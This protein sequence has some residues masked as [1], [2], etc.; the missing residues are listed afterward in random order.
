MNAQI[1]SIG[2]ELAGGQT[3]DTNAAWLAR[4]LAMLGI[5]CSK[6]VTIADELVPIR[7]S[8]VSVS[9]EADL[10]LITGGLGPTPDDLTRTALAEAMG[11]RLRFHQ[12]S[13]ARIEAFFKA[14]KR[15]MHADNRNQAMFPESAEPIENGCGTAPGIYA[16]LNDADIFCLPGVPYEMKAMFEQSVRPR[17]S[18]DVRQQTILHQTLRTFGM[19]EAEVGDKLS[20]LMRRDRNPNVGTSAAD[21]VISVRFHARGSSESEASELIDRDAAEIRRRLGKV[22]FGESEDTL[23]DAVAR[24]LIERRQTLST[25]ESC[26]G[27]LLAKRLTDVSGASSYLIQGIVAYAN[28][29]KRD[30]LQIPMDLIETHGAVSAQVAEAMAVNCRRLS[31]T[32]YALAVTGIAGPTGATPGK[33]VGLVYIA[34]AAPV[35]TVVKELRLGENLTRTQ[36]RDRTAKIALNLLRL[37]LI[38][39]S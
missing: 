23:A 16:R 36:I 17:F 13:F 4:Q 2:S 11:V 20:D 26:T 35:E 22:V 14:R 15:R 38:G 9:R 12:V 21:L 28:E 19:S 33:P 3:V 39:H 37:Q 8:I 29:A 24:L 25:A 32:D 10:L 30:L 7:D 5:Q 27:G 34:L 18:D 6:H 1:I 31:A